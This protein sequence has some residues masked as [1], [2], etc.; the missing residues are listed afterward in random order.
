MRAK[1]K[2]MP[3]PPPQRVAC[4]DSLVF[5]RG[6]ARVGATVQELVDAVVAVVRHADVDGRAGRKRVAEA[7]LVAVSATGEAHEV[8]V[9]ASAACVRRA[10]RAE[11]C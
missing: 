10:D 1:V 4:G 11:I 7:G 9:A 6:L 3:E 5:H 8:R 2:L